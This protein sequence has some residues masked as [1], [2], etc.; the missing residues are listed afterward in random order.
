MNIGEK[1]TEGI[2]WFGGESAA[3]GT[4]GSAGPPS[5]SPSCQANISGCF[6]FHR[7]SITI[8]RKKMRKL[9]LLVLF[10]SGLFAVAAPSAYGSGEAI[11][12]VDSPASLEVL[13]GVTSITLVWAAANPAVPTRGNGW[14]GPNGDEA[15]YYHPDTFDQLDQKTL[16]HPDKRAGTHI[17]G[18][19]VP[20]NLPGF[21]GPDWE[22]RMHQGA[23]AGI[24]TF[25]GFDPDDY[26]NGDNGNLPPVELGTA[27][28]PGLLYG[29]GRKALGK[30]WLNDPVAPIIEE[31][32]RLVN[33]NHLGHAESGVGNVEDV[34]FG[35]FDGKVTWTIEKSGWDRRWNIYIE[36]VPDLPS[37]RLLNGTHKPVGGITYHTGGMPW[38]DP[39]YVAFDKTDGDITG[40]VVVTGAIITAWQNGEDYEVGDVAIFEKRWFECIQDHKANYDKNRPRYGQDVI[41]GTGWV[42]Y[43]EEDL[44]RKDDFDLSGNQR[45]IDY[46][47]PGMHEVTYTV[48][49]SA[50]ATNFEVRKIQITE[51]P[52]DSFFIEVFPEPSEEQNFCFIGSLLAD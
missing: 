18:D 8:R 6:R 38:V 50:G 32:D 20:E 16:E 49:N 7:P 10:L 2:P 22:V 1:T 45:T 46:W 31:G 3:K 30:F 21:L 27:A 35:G 51:V 25:N 37:I 36:L 44:G 24:I 47:S 19:G 14:I 42:D 28:N 33:L 11:F 17:S 9:G 43:W 26:S 41:A 4:V 39:G 13:E 12:Y 5:A 34:I 52:P 15:I 48:T 23:N 40:S 29:G